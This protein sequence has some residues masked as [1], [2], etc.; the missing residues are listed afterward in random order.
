MVAEI[1]NE[2]ASLRAQ[3]DADGY[4]RASA[5]LAQHWRQ[6]LDVMALGTPPEQRSCP[7]CGYGIN[8]SATRCIQCWK[9]SRSSPASLP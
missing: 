7:H 2:L 1:E 5:R 9:Q 3:A 8:A 6:L 4:A